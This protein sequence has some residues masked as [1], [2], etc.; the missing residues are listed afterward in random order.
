MMT[1][2]VFGEQVIPEAKIVK[3]QLHLDLKPVGSM[4]AEVAR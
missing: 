2:P 3:N 1:G 4:A